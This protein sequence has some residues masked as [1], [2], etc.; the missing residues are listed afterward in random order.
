MAYVNNQYFEFHEIEA[1]T[2]LKWCWLIGLSIEQTWHFLYT[3]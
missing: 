1:F 2:K 3:F